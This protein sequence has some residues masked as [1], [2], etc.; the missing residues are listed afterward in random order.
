MC[1]AFF[2][3][4]L[5]TVSLLAMV[6]LGCASVFADPATPYSGITNPSEQRGLNFNIPGVV[7]KVYVKEGDEVKKGMIVAQQDDSVE[8][9]EL[10]VKEAEAKSSELQIKAANAD[11]A[12]KKVEAK[13]SEE[14]FAKHVLGKSEL[15]KAIL[16][17]TIG[18]IRVQLAEQ[19]TQQK[20]KEADA[21]K[22]KIAQK[23]LIATI[24]GVVQKINVHEGE[25]ATNDPK[26][27]C[28]QLVLN[29]PIWVEVDLP[30]A[31]AKTLKKGQ[32]M[33]VKYTDETVWE[34]APIIYLNPMASAASGTQRV[35]LELANPRQLRSGLQIEVRPIDQKAV[36]STPV[37]K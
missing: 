37:A 5:M 18:E 17:V 1:K 10:V 4:R 9:A 8:Q 27:P 15:E 21:Q 26:T 7:S 12:Q 32:I 25:L 29:T 33:E 16:D 19:E 22:A 13:R 3:R 2:G 30:V 35:R 6:G 36:A 24:D 23:K 28:L 20:H 34:K 14:M 31:D 11:L